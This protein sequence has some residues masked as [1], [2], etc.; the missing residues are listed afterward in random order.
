[1][2]RVAR[3]IKEEKMTYP[4]RFALLGGIACFYSKN[5]SNSERFLPEKTKNK[6]LRSYETTYK[7]TIGANRNGF[8]SRLEYLR[9]FDPTAPHEEK[10]SALAELYKSEMDYGFVSDHVVASLRYIV[11]NLHIEDGDWSDEILPGSFDFENGYSGITDLLTPLAK[12]LLTSKEDFRWLKK[13]T[14]KEEFSKHLDE[15][16]KE[17][18]VRSFREL[19]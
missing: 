10:T 16:C 19:N 6:F 12:E 14:H 2:K 18:K 1:M 13:L 3:K 7:T 4:Y 11:E 15:N 8:L 5:L 9:E 17:L